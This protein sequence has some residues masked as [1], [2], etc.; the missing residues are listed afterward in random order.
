MSAPV[1]ITA[2]KSAVNAFTKCMS[3]RLSIALT[4]RDS[5]HSA[6]NS[7]MHPPNAPSAAETSPAKDSSEIARSALSIKSCTISI[8]MKL[9][10]P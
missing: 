9:Y 6:A 2:K 4:L 3:G 7:A 5:A 10:P 1:S 8:V